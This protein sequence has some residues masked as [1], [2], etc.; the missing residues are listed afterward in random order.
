MDTATPTNYFNPFFTASATSA[1]ATPTST[2]EPFMRWDG[3]CGPNPK[4]IHGAGPW[5][6]LIVPTIFSLI[7]GAATIVANARKKKAYDNMTCKMMC[8]NSLIFNRLFCDIIG[9]MMAVGVVAA[10]VHTTLPETSIRAGLWGAFLGPHQGSLVALWQLLD[11]EA[12]IPAIVQIHAEMPLTFLGLAHIYLGES[13]KGPRIAVKAIRN[14]VLVAAWIFGAALISVFCLHL[15]CRLISRESLKSPL[16]R[17]IFSIAGLLAL[18]AGLMMVVEGTHG[19]V[20]LW[21]LVI[22]WEQFL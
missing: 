17:L 13:G 2:D 4:L 22:Y 20:S 6:G 19:A 3:T 8:F 11:R 10:I 1:A 9:R 12:T 21:V 15:L 14:P 7:A 18:I 5:V 16:S